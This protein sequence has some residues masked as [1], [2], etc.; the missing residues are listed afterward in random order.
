[1]GYAH[2][3]RLTALDASFLEMETPAVHMH[4]GSVGI[5]QSGPLA[6]AGGGVDFDRIRSIVEAGLRRAP[7]FRQKLARRPGVRASGLGR[8]PAASTS[9]YHV[10]HTALPTSRR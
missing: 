9:T 8:R 5:F 2:Y 3:D 1:M 10:R 4:V 6:R 7:R